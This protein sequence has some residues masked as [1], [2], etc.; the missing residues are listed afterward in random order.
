MTPAVLAAKAPTITALLGD[1]DPVLAFSTLR[2][3]AMESA[4]DVPALAA[5]ASLGLTSDGETHLNRLDDFGADQ[6]YE[7]RQSRRYSDA[8]LRQL[9][10]LIA[11]HWPNHTVPQLHVMAI[12]RGPDS[13]DC[14]ITTKR[15]PHVQMRPVS[16]SLHTRESTL[17]L[18]LTERVRSTDDW[19]ANAYEAAHLPLGSTVALTLVWR[20]ELWPLFR[21]TWVGQ[22]DDHSASSTALGAKLMLE[23]ELVAA[24][25]A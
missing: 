24:V 7:A 19:I 8:G 15:L 20:G 23:L 25:S 3:R 9:A 11:G 4:P 5:L 1:G 18:P 13:V 21:V 14:R 16:A 6:G 10:Q 12:R 22:F 17:D 2:V